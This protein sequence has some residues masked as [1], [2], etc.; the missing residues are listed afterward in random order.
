MTWTPV[1]NG[2]QRERAFRIAGTIAEDLRQRFDARRGAPEHEAW[3]LAGWSGAALFFAYYGLATDDQDALEFA[4]R[5]VE[6]ALEAAL[7]VASLAR[8]FDGLTG[9]AWTLAHVDGWLLDASDNDPNLA[10]EAAL[11]EAVSTVPWSGEY[12]LLAGLV[13]V[14]VYAVERL[15]RPLAGELLTSVVDRLAELSEQDPTHP[16]WWSPAGSLPAQLRRTFPGGAWNLGL[17]HGLP[18][19][20]G[21]LAKSH[22]AGVVSAGPLLDRSVEWLFDQRLPANAGSVLPALC[23]PYLAPRRSPLAWCYGDPGAS[24]ALFVAARHAGPTDWETAALSVAEAAAARSLT[25]NSVEERSICH[26]SAGLAHIFNRLYQATENA[27]MRRATE[28][29]LLTTMDAC[30]PYVPPDPDLLM[31]SPGI[32][33]V[34]LAAATTVEPR[35]DRVLLMS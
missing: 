8:L 16:L 19:V 20:I 27:S 12:D 17:A 21:L 7:G 5:L 1:L 32:G 18:G 15:P 4:A 35:W 22:A 26:G 31:G 29:W 24:I 3:S 33:L 25:D 34:L 28:A 23:A 13:G 9:V 2:C 30:Q 11:L 6:E 10:I 14:G